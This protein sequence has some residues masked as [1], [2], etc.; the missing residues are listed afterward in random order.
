MTWFNSY[1]TPLVAVGN[2]FYIRI[3]Q[4]FLWTIGVASVVLLHSDMLHL[5]E[6]WND[7]LVLVC[8]CLMALNHSIVEGK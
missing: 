5:G 6:A 8:M 2:F 4:L 1:R 3:R 7:R